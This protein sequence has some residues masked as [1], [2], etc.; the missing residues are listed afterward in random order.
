MTVFTQELLMADEKYSRCAWYNGNIVSREEG[1]PS[2]AS[3][4]FHL[5]TSVFDGMM[6]YWNIDHYYLHRGEAH[7]DRFRRGAER[8]GLIIPWSTDEMLAG[9]VDLMSREASCTYY[10]RPIAYRRGPELWIADSESRSVDVSIFLVRIDDGRDI[11]APITCELSPIERISSRAV[12]GH[13]KVSGAYVNSVYARRTAKM[14][15]FDDGVMFDREGRLAEASAANVFVIVGELLLTPPTNP[16]LF[17]GITRQVILEL[18]RAKGIEAKEIDLRRQDLE[19]INGAFLCST[20]MEIRG[21]S[22]LG[23]SPLSTV[24]L[25]VFQALLGAFRSMTHQ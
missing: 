10:I 8:M 6:A 22:R 24:E 17:P 2:V 18:A 12:P 9:V 25:P 1:A 14:S 7:F 23:S 11:D 13:L 19:K 21:I 15:G 16:D 4:S 3:A 20:L 5:G